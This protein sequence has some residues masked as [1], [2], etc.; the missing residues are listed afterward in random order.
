MFTCL[1]LQSRLDMRRCYQGYRSVVLHFSVWI[2]VG[3]DYQGYSSTHVMP[4]MKNMAMAC[5]LLLFTLELRIQN[6]AKKQTDVN[7]SIFMCFDIAAQI[8]IFGWWCSKL[9]CCSYYTRASHIGFIMEHWQR[10]WL[11]G[12]EHFTFNCEPVDKH[13]NVWINVKSDSSA[14]LSWVMLWTLFFD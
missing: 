12:H 7:L 5:L 6:K 9:F 8:D 1:W 4:W 13:V 10:V 14:N 2:K 3:D 11:E